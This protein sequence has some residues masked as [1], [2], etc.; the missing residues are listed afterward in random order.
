MMANERVPSGTSPHSRC[1]LILADNVTGPSTTGR[2]RPC[3]SGITPSRSK[4]ELMSLMI[5]RIP[6]PSSEGS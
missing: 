3:R 6:R 2:A 5:S 1:G 4:L